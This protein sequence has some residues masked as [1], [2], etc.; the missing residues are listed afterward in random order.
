MPRSPSVPVQ[1]YDQVYHLACDQA[2]PQAIKRAAAFLDKKMHEAA[3]VAGERAPLDI[4]I[5]AAM[6]VAEG[7]IKEKRKKTDLVEDADRR[8]RSFAS[9]LED[10]AGLAPPT[11]PRF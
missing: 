5:L 6:G 7:L 2:D 8:L 3:A 1:I 4:A 9:R 11:T 10:Q